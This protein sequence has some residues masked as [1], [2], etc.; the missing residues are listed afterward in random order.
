VV[1][2]LFLAAASLTASTSAS[3]LDVVG[4]TS[5]PLGFLATVLTKERA[6]GAGRDHR[7]TA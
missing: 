4:S 3:A 2:P 7:Q 6:A 1:S 5:Q